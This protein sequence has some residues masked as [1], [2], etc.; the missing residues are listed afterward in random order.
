VG[1]PRL[2]L[3]GGLA[4]RRRVALLVE[5]VVD[6]LEGEAHALA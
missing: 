1:L 5:D 2:V 6:D 4:E 3:A